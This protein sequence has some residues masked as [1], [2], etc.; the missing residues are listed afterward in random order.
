MI[1]TANAATMQA[2][3]NQMGLGRHQHHHQV[4]ESGYTLIPSNEQARQ[5]LY[6][7][8][9]SEDQSEEDIDS[10]E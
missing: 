3:A 1:A 7:F 5:Q 10:E 8:D 4:A 2:L 6:N 9:Y